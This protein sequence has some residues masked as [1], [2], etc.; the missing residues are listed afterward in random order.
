MTGGGVVNRPNASRAV[1]GNSRSMGEGWIRVDAS[2]LRTD[3]A[4]N[5]WL[6][7]TTRYLDR[8]QTAHT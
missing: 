4:F 8:R 7:A 1:M 5:N 3:A 6:Q 2:A